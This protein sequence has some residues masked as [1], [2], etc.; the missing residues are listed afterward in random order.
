MH[1]SRCDHTHMG[2]D[3][4]CAQTVNVCAHE[5]LTRRALYPGHA[6]LHHVHRQVTSNVM[7]T[8]SF[9]QHRT[10]CST[11]PYADDTT[12]AQIPQDVTLHAATLHHERVHPY[13][14]DA[15]S[16]HV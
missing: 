1:A 4:S 2:V 10:M 16:V 14:Y 6:A 15:R 7:N 12:C 5:T 9:T 13:A 8:K 3:I 11:A